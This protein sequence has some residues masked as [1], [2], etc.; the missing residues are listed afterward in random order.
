MQGYALEENPTPHM[1]SL[2]D[3]RTILGVP[4]SLE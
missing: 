1:A 3:E 2:T 4:V